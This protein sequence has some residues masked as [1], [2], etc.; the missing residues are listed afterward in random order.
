M[1]CALMSGDTQAGLADAARSAGLAAFL[2]KSLDVDALLEA[3]RAIARGD[4][5]FPPSDDA[6]RTTSALTS[7]QQEIVGLAAGGASSKEIARRLGISPTTVRNHFCL[8]FERLGARNRAQAV[9]LAARASATDGT[10]ADASIPN[11]T[12]R[13]SR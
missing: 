13:H 2:P 8:I 4:R 9:A 1:A 7:R 10:P 6:G 11:I 3:L 5:W 12:T